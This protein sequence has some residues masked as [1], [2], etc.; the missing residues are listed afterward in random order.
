MAWFRWYEGATTDPKFHVVSR[1]SGQPVAFV[2]AVWALLLERASA[3]DDRGNAEGFDCESADA[4]LGMPDGAAEAIVQAME[5]KGLLSDLHVVKWE[6]RQPRREDTTSTERSRE[7]RARK[8]AEATQGDDVQHDATDATPCNAVQRNATQGDD[9]QH[10]ATLDKSRVDKKRREEKKKEESCGEQASPAHRRQPPKEP[11]PLTD[12]ALPLNTGELW[13]VPQADYENWCQLYPSVDVAQ[14]LR[15]M[16]G[17]CDSNPKR[18]KTKNGIRAFCT[19]WLSKDQNV[20]LH[21]RASPQTQFQDVPRLPGQP[22]ADTEYQRQMQDRRLMVQWL[23]Q[24]KDAEEAGLEPPPPLI[25]LTAL[26]PDP[27]GSPHV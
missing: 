11:E 1:K 21:G 16:R 17:W 27:G 7:Y 25:D 18:R 3:A 9:V 20:G 4:V 2:V 14:A 12:F 15:S 5:N 26:P 23:K 24:V 13:Y 6:A 19:S 8:K 10:D 22:R